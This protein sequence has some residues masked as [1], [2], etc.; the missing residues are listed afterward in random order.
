MAIYTTYEQIGLAEDVKDDISM[1]SPVDS[2]VASMSKNTQAT[3]RIHEFQEDELDAIKQNIHLEG[4]AAGTDNSVPTVMR[5]VNCQIFKETAEISRTAERVKKYGRAS[6]MNY[7]TMKRKLAMIRDEESAIAGDAG[8][9]GRQAGAAGAAGTERELTSIYSQVDATNLVYATADFLVGGVDITTTVQLETCLVEAMQR[10][11]D[12]GGN[13]N[14]AITD[15]LVAGFFPSFALSAGRN[16]DVVGGE[17]FNYVD[18]YRSQFG[19]YDVVIDR[20]MTNT[21]RAIL[22]MD[23]E[24][25][26][27]PILDPTQD[28]ALAKDGDRERREIVRESTYALTNSKAAAIVDA[29]PATLA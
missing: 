25:S 16:V 26:E 8:G 13:G 27:T 11:F 6:E 18:I 10:L 23:F 28:Y 19:S 5:S 12:G 7:Q 14:Y 21:N 1:I 2:P 9:A 22:L 15:S 24:F 20:S 4:S 29:I 3:A 17:L